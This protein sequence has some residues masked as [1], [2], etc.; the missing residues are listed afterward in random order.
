MEKSPK[1]NTKNALVVEDEPFIREFCEIA[2]GDDGFQVDSVENGSIALNML[3]RKDYD[4]CLIDIRT[5]LMNGIEL[6][7]Q[8][9]KESL[10][11][12]TRVV[13]ITGDTMNKD[14]MDFIAKTKRPLLPKPFAIDELKSIVGTIQALNRDDETLI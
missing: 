7:Q 14:V 5:P 2:L 4:V 8:L 13:F 11:L 10:Q 6:F 9:E 12:V 1:L 3:R